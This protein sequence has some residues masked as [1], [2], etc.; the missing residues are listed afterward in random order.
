MW[1]GSL[2]HIKNQII[3]CIRVAIFWYELMIWFF[4]VIKVPYTQTLALLLFWYHEILGLS[5]YFRFNGRL[6]TGF[7]LML[8]IVVLQRIGSKIFILE[9]NFGAFDLYGIWW[10]IGYW[11]MIPVV[12]IVVIFRCWLRL[13]I[14]SLLIL[15]S[16]S[17]LLCSKLSY[18]L[19][20]TV[21]HFLNY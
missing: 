7:I 3:G 9:C 12:R 18:V 13:V 15:V 8:T 11:L 6:V 5:I 21:W 14:C 10:P 1:P 17:Y 4:F 16:I 20:W 2:V 19:P